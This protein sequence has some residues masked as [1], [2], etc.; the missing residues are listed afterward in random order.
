MC[1]FWSSVMLTTGKYKGRPIP[2]HV[3]ITE[4]APGHFDEWLALFEVTANELFTPTLAAAFVDKAKRIAE[5]L[6]LGLAFHSP[7]P[8]IW[9]E[10]PPRAIPLRTVR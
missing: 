3:K 10:L 2:A 4:I 9:A 8:E 6:K 1:D 7:T 5:S